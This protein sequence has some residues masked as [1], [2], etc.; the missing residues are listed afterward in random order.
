MFVIGR[1]ISQ[2]TFGRIRVISVTQVAQMS[3]RPIG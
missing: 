1:V 3:Q 2:E